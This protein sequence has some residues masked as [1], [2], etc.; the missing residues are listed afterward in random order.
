[1]SVQEGSS[2]RLTPGRVLVV[3]AGIYVTQ[4]LLGSIMFMGIPAV[5][6]SGGIPLDRIG[7]T[8]LFML[9]WTV[10]FLWSPWVE[11][12]RL[13]P[14]GRRRSLAFII[15]AQG[16]IVALLAMLAFVTPAGGLNLLLAGMALV[17]L[18]AATLDIACDGFTV[19]QLRDRIRGWGNVMQVG[20]GYL[21]IAFGSGL[22]LVLI[23]R[24]GWQTGMLAMAGIALILTLPAVLTREPRGLPASASD[25]RPSLRVAL[26]RAPIRWGLVLVV[27][28]Q[29]GGRLIQ[30]ITGPFLIDQGVD[31]ATLG[32]VNGSLGIAISLAGVLIAGLAVRRWSVDRLL[33]AVLLLHALT[34]LTTLGAL[35]LGD[36]PLSLY[37][38]LAL[39][40]SAVMAGGF[41]VLYTAAMNWSSLRQAGVD[42]TLFQ[43]ADAATAA[44]AGVTAGVLAHHAGYPATF[45]VALTALIFAALLLP[46]LLRRIAV[47]A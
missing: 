37:L 36:M 6:R 1:M 32:T 17:A 39:L 28:F 31:L 44:A 11:R 2:G 18:I 19:E 42:F 13:P 25:P 40:E 7:L 21:G 4:S 47:S 24:Q 43:C 3:I 29:T 27:L 26:A 16:L 35:L 38:A 33:M 34:F 23:E 15:A 9:P 20:G 10:K 14:D 8:A 12:F 45:G 5:L 46:G 41:V 30:G 22:F